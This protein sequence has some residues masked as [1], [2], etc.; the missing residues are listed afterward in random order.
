MN[1]EKRDPHLPFIAAVWGWFLASVTAVLAAGNIDSTYKWA[2]EQPWA[3]TILTLPMARDRS[4]LTIWKAYAWGEN[5]GWIRLGTCNGGDPVLRHTSATNYGV[6]ND[7]G[8]NLSGLAGVRT[9]AD[10]L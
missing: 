5:I 7:G 2:W 10:Q 1:I 6:N 8:G 4:I 9:R 3:G